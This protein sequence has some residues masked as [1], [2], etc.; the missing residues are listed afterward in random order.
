MSSNFA[1]TKAN[2]LSYSNHG[3]RALQCISRTYF[4][5]DPIKLMSSNIPATDTVLVSSVRSQ[6]DN[7]LRI[8]GEVSNGRL[9]SR[10][11]AAP[12][13]CWSTAHSIFRTPLPRVSASWQGWFARQRYILRLTRTVSRVARLP[14]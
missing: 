4:S 9:C 1:A 7:K 6:E 12:C 10:T 14:E 13:S 2:G 11:N 3:C 5:A 8:G